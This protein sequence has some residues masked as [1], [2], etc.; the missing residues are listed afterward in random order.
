M[1]FGRLLSFV[2]AG[3][4][5]GCVG[6]FTRTNQGPDADQT[7]KIPINA[8]TVPLTSSGDGITLLLR[9]MLSRERFAL[10]QVETVGSRLA[11]R[12][13]DP[14]QFRIARYSSTGEMLDMMHLWSPLDRFEWDSEGQRERRVS[15]VEARV[16]IP[17]PAHIGV[18]G[19]EL[20]WPDG[21][22]LG[23]ID[24]SSALQT[25]CAKAP[26]NPGCRR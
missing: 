2:I 16:E 8:G 3:L 20:Q 6:T 7:T 22:R 13:P 14:D 10:E 15:V 11:S 24:V 18:A 4:L 5:V 21:A 23:R 1:R 12:S 26:V 19:I 25:F 9:G 17:V